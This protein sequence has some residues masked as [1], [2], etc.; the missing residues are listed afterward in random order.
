MALKGHSVSGCFGVITLCSFIVLSIIL[1]ASREACDGQ[2]YPGIFTKPPEVG[3]NVTF[4]PTFPPT[5][6]TPT[7]LAPTT[8]TPSNNSSRRLLQIARNTSA[9]TG[10]PTYVVNIKCSSWADAMDNYMKWMLACGTACALLGLIFF[11][12]ER[13]ATARDGGCVSM[14]FPRYFPTI[15]SHCRFKSDFA[16]RLATPFA[17]I[18]SGM[19]LG[20][21]VVRYQI[22]PIGRR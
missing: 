8:A 14:D 13:F 1:E 11:L 22:P 2:S 5:T 20:G 7:T 3:P 18:F 9:P 10:V 17:L 16:Q 6:P 19:W 15:Q 4:A 21:A 12:I